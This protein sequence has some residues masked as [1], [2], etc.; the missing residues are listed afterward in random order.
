MNEM[1]RKFV[2]HDSYSLELF[3]ANLIVFQRWLGTKA[4]FYCP[5]Q[6]ISRYVSI[7][8]SDKLLIQKSLNFK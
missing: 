8:L 4:Y 1:N 7:V 3:K 6:I 5:P 2:S